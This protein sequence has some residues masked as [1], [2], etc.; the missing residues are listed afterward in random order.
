MKLVFALYIRILKNTTRTVLLPGALQGITRFA[1][2]VNVD[3]FK[4]LMNTLKDIVAEGIDEKPEA[5]IS[6]DQV[7][8]LELEVGGTE[9]I[10][11][12]LQC[13]ITAFELLTG[14]GN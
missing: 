5:E 3:F 11:L 1:H 12:R 2:L 8:A 4:D 6:D 7:D 9:W 10:A 13:I 14:Q